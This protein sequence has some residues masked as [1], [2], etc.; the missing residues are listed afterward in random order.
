MIEGE[1]DASSGPKRNGR[2]FLGRLYQLRGWPPGWHSWTSELDDM[3]MTGEVIG[4][5]DLLGGLDLCKRLDFRL[6]H[7]PG[8]YIVPNLGIYSSQV[9]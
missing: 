1:D 4:G 5:L 6:L 7:M 8:V 2:H 3:L 9:C